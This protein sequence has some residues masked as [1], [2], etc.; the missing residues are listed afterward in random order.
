MCILI[1]HNMHS[2][3]YNAHKKQKNV[4]YMYNDKAA[5]LNWKNEV[6]GK[7]FKMNTHQHQ[8]AF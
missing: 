2:Y 1:Y 4:M 5:P 8:I 7:Q 6:P 3:I